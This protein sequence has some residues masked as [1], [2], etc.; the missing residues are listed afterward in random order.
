MM[1]PGLRI[2]MQDTA[3][4]GRDWN[5]VAHVDESL[6]QFAELNR[7]CVEPRM[8]CVEFRNRIA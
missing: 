1:L 4:R 2:A 3:D 6:Q 8:A 7:T 5:G